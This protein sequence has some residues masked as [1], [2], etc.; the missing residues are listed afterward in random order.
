MH[1]RGIIGFLHGHFTRTKARSIAARV[2]AVVMLCEQGCAHWSFERDYAACSEAPAETAAAELGMTLHPPAPEAFDTEAAASFSAAPPWEWGQSRVY[3][4]DYGFDYTALKQGHGIR[5]ETPLWCEI[6]FDRR[7]RMGLFSADPL[8][9]VDLAVVY[10]VGDEVPVLNQRAAKRT[11]RVRILDPIHRFESTDMLGFAVTDVDWLERYGFPTRD[12]IATFRLEYGESLAAST[13]IRWRGSTTIRCQHLDPEATAAAREDTLARFDRSLASFSPAYDFEGFDAGANDSGL[14]RLRTLLRR[15]ASLGHGWDD[16][17]LRSRTEALLAR[18]SCFERAAAEPIHRK[19]R[20]MTRGRPLRGLRVGPAGELR[21]ESSAKLPPDRWPSGTCEFD[22]RVRTSDEA[23]PIHS[24]NLR[25]VVVVLAGGR[26][27][28][29]WPIDAPVVVPG[30]EAFVRMRLEPSV[31][32]S[33][34]L[35]QP[36]MLRWRRKRLL[37][38]LVVTSWPVEP[39]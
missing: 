13:G 26:E 35:T 32:E 39:R 36:V 22:L 23:G 11:E 30:A 29:A 9:R 21:C 20:M 37:G 19:T 5:G 27:V 18:Q 16:P 10:S 38:G 7:R 2:A 4:R 12:D 6:E 15:A 24:S 1:A 34:P 33:V 28:E 31:T 3:P 8:T 14:G 25:G 17:E